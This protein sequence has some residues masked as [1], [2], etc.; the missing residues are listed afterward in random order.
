MQ[1]LKLEDL[2]AFQNQAGNWS[3]V[4]DVLVNPH[5]DINQKTFVSAEVVPPA[6]P[7][8]QKRKWWQRKPPVPQSAPA[9]V[10]IPDPVAVISSPGTGILLNQNTDSQKDHLLTKWEHGDIILELD[11]MVPKGSNSGIYLQGRYEVQLLDSW[12][13]SNPAYSDIGGIYRNWEKTPGQIYMGKAP[14]TNAA[15]APGTWQHFK[16]AFQAPHS[17]GC[18]CR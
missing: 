7:L 3:I 5:V 17:H 18:E 9:T 11:V 10:K 8:V 4:G 13:K 14:L 1:S 2:S 6:T 16:I 12:G 15:K